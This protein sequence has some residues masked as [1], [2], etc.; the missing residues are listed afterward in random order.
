TTHRLVSNIVLAL[1]EI[2]RKKLTDLDKDFFDKICLE[3]INNK[4]DVDFSKLMQAIDPIE[5]VKSRKIVGGPSPDTVRSTIMNKEKEL[6]KLT[7][8]ISSLRDFL[9][10]A[11]EKLASFSYQ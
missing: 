1:L 8:Q 4:L 10:Q 11:K 7:N 5:S 9:E 2:G 6:E 3:T